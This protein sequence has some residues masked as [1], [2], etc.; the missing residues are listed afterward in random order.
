MTAM[1]PIVVIPFGQKVRLSNTTQFMDFDGNPVDPDKVTFAFSIDGGTPYIF[2]YTTGATPPDPTYSVVR[3]GV[4]SYYMDVFTASY[5]PGV[6]QCSIY[7]EPT[8]ANL[9][10]T[11]T[12]ARDNWQFVVTEPPFS[13]S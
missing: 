13:L 11:K 5:A 6:W 7:G 3:N 9:D 12:A 4:G 10:A 2:T 1:N 8:S